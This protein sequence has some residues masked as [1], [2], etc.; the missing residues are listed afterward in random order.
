MRRA[1]G[2]LDHDACDRPLDGSGYP[3]GDTR[4]KVS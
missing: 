4:T 2:A 3:G 1:D